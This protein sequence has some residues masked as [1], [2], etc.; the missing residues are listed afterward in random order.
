[1]KVNHYQNGQ[2]FRYIEP[3]EPFHRYS[4]YQRETDL[5]KARA[6]GWQS[7]R[8]AIAL[9]TM[10]HSPSA[11]AATTLRGVEKSDAASTMFMQRNYSRL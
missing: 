4:A 7:R 2:C 11:I 10:P 6:P 3:K 1:V 5:V 8:V 9:A